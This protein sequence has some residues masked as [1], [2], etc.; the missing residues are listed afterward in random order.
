MKNTLR[1]RFPLKFKIFIL[2]NFVAMIALGIYAWIAFDQFKQDKE[3]YVFESTMDSTRMAAEVIETELS[4]VNTLFYLLENKFSD[5]T[6]KIQ[7]VDVAPAKS[8]LKVRQFRIFNHKKNKNIYYINK[9]SNPLLDLRH[10]GMEKID[11]DEY[12]VWKRKGDHSM[13]LTY[14]TNVFERVVYARKSMKSFILDKQGLVLSRNFTDSEMKINARQMKR[15]MPLNTSKGTFSYLDNEGRE[16]LVAFTRVYPLGQEMVVFSFIPKAVAFRSLEYLMYKSIAL[17]MIILS[18]SMLVGIFFARR[19]T[20]P[21]MALTKGAKKI[22]EGEFG[23]TVE[24]QSRD[25]IGVLGTVFNQM[26]TNIEDLMGQLHQYNE[27]LE[28]M[29]EERTLQLKEA[30]DLQKTLTDSVNSGFLMFDSKGRIDHVYSVA[31]VNIFNSTIEGNNITDLIGIEENEKE[32]FLEFLQLYF[33]GMLN[34]VDTLPFLPQSKKTIDNRNLVFDYYPVEENGTPTRIVMVANDNTAQV[35]AETDARRLDDYNKAITRILKNKNIFLELLGEIMAYRPKASAMVEF[36]HFLHTIKGSL[37]YFSLIDFGQYVHDLETDIKNQVSFHQLELTYMQIQD[38][39]QEFVKNISYL[40]GRNELDSDE[41]FKEV[42][43]QNL[44]DYYQRILELPHGRKL[45][46]N[47]Q[48]DLVFS[49][50]EEL[51]PDYHQEVKE[52]GKILNKNVRLRI[53]GGHIKVMPGIYD[54]AFKQ[55]SHLLRNSVDHGV[56]HPDIRK[57]MN[58]DLEGE[59]KLNFYDF[60]G[61]YLMITIQDDGKGIDLPMLREK[62]GNPAAK[63]EDIIFADGFSSKENATIL[64]GRGVGLSSVKH[65]VEA[66]EGHLDVDSLKNAGV[67][68]IILIPRFDVAISRR[69]LKLVA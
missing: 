26:S 51:I 63:I 27:H 40:F 68:F 64:S 53:S 7:K 66:M 57:A 13:I 4:D 47:F 24:T 35:K 2:I 32:S 34:F 20:K 65:V 41:I 3:A 18:S 49:S 38:Q 67:I 43:V 9:D 15:L 29:V 31:T 42:S 52:A 48:H 62:V 58:K 33:D 19:I 12:A 59:I 45:A 25:E 10:D 69:N 30:L 6:Y 44:Q 61:R 55:L 37:R 23:T 17:V 22:A 50:I 28:D 54:E 5:E 1:V 56:E 39:L 14:K 36:S 46:E 16:Q 21:V 8:M 11:D 60:M